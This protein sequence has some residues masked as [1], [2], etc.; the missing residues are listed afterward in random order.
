MKKILFTALLIL[1]SLYSEEKPADYYQELSDNIRLYFDIML[2]LNENYVDTANIEE[3]M[4]EGIRAMLSKTDPYTVLLKDNEL[5]HFNEL[6]SGTYGGIGIYLGTSGSDKRLTV[7]SPMDDTPASKV[8]L[9]AG[10]QIMFIDDKDTYGMS[11]RDASKYLKGEPGTKLKIKIRRIGNSGF[12]D[13]NITRASIEI[14]N[15]PYTEIIEGDIGYIKATEFSATLYH[16]FMIEFDK[17]ISQGAKSLIVD[18]RY[19]PGGLL[20]SAVKLSGAFLPKNKLVVSTRG[21]S[22]ENETKYRTYLDPADTEIPIVV[23]INGSSASASEIF[24]GAL[25]DHDRAVILG[26]D[27]FGKGLVQ[28]LF[29]VGNYKKRNLKMTIRKYYTP[30]GRLIQ[31]DDIF[32]DKKNTETDTLYY[33][34]LVNGR[35]LPSGIGIVPDILIEQKKNTDYVSYLRMNNYFS[36]FVYDQFNSNKDYVYS[37]T[38]DDSVL[39][40]FQEYLV[41]EKAE[42]VSP[43]EVL[44]DSL[45]SVINEN[46]YSENISSDIDMIKSK[47]RILSGNVFLDNI[48][49]IRFNLQIEFGVYTNGNKEKYRLLNTNDD[50]IRAAVDLL[51]HKDRYQQILGY[52]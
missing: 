47:F 20:E 41:L 7:I 32:G 15:I 17:L 22:P 35:D 44:L 1:N 10:D 14:K 52:E 18:L 24:A 26:E 36:D 13:F 21:R 50:Q 6:S 16:D 27:S 5:D 51:R 9:R 19:N 4:N 46:G 2:S 45:I 48:D 39:K 11:V 12:L 40:K 49:D 34:S 37:G 23:L 28:Q 29:D 8:G 42:Y 33:K 43:G 38:V 31:K 3:L 25:Q 30:T